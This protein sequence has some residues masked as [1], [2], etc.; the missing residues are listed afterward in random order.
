MT[1][2]EAMKHVAAGE[3]VSRPGW[4]EVYV[5]RRDHELG[6]LCMRDYRPTPAVNSYGVEVP[7]AKPAPL[8][9]SDVFATD[10]YVRATPLQR[11]EPR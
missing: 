3:D 2:E 1:F 8:L 9:F 10:W 5:V 6:F 11:E 4:P 7:H